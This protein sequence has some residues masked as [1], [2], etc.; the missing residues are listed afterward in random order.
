MPMRLI[1]LFALILLLAAPLA[2]AG[3][4]DAPGADLQVSLIT[5]GPGATYWERFGHDAIE[6]RDRVS[7][8]SV[9][10]NYGVFDFNA[11]GFLLNFARG[12]MT[13]LMD[14]EPTEPEEAW[15]VQVGRS[16]TRQR[17]ALAPAQAAALRDYLLWNLRPENVHY[18][19][20]YYTSNC[21]TKVRDALNRA[22][23]GIIEKTLSGEPARLTWRQQTNRLMSQQPWLM[24]ILD[25]GQGPY[26]DQPLNAWQESYLPMVQQRE[27]RQIRL[28][29][30]DG[31]S[32]PLVA[33]ETVLSPSRL[34]S[35]PV[36]P[37]DL[38]LPLGAAGLLLAALLVAGRLYWP[39]G[40]S[41]L[42]TVYLLLAGVAGL[43]MLILWT[44]TAHRVAWNNANLLLFN[45]LAFALVGSLWRA[46][47]NLP[48][49][50]FAH[51]LMALQLLA[52]LA[53]IALH[54]LPGVVQQNQPWIAFAL[55]AWLAL[56][57]CQRW[58]T[59]GNVQLR[60]PR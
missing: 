35:P 31:S 20:D 43:L 47:R 19:Y 42:G 15:Y 60:L 48:A 58:S 45:P 3:I 46:R 44:L 32:R 17:L 49:S 40:A 18:R 9:N 51:A 33:A 2:H 23:G 53:A 39:T 52:V 55:P 4:A 10:F 22:V 26:A 27:L 12:R 50:R 24:L 38:R 36:N 28:P 59:P 56:A 1:A 54:A 16:I 11:S 6:L 30:P 8:E 21:S 25:L 13:Y 14:A 7:G 5:Y 57:R 41:L 29:N 34:A 37:P